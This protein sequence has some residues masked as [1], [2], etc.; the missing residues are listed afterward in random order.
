M[1]IQSLPEGSRNGGTVPNRVSAFIHAICLHLALINRM[2]NFIWTNIINGSRNIVFIVR[3]PQTQSNGGEN[4]PHP[5]DS[6]PQLPQTHDAGRNLEQ[7]KSLPCML[8]NSGVCY[9]MV[10]INR[11]SP[12]QG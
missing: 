8:E 3:T 5:L 2:L 12:D 1:G 10:P 11:H 6:R 4:V 7:W 9:D